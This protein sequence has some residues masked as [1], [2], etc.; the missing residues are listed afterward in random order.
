[1][2]CYRNTLAVFH[3]PSPWMGEGTHRVPGEDV[4]VLEPPYLGPPHPRPLPPSWGEGILG[5]RAVKVFR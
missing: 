5:G 1:M 3:P 2:Y 4:E